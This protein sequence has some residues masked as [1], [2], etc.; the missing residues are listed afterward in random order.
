MIKLKT[1]L[2]KFNDKLKAQKAD[3]DKKIEIP[4]VQEIKSIQQLI[5]EEKKKL[6]DEFNPRK[7]PTFYKKL[8][9]ALFEASWG[10]QMMGSYKQILDIRKEG[11]LTSTKARI[12][13]QRMTGKGKQSW[14][15]M[16]WMIIGYS[17]IVI[18]LSAIIVPGFVMNYV[19]IQIKNG[20]WVEIPITNEAKP[21]VVEEAEDFNDE[22]KKED[23]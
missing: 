8:M 9:K 19:K 17:F 2:S 22:F 23:L 1:Q 16:V 15:N 13:K 3:L 5:I 21:T 14:L 11:I 12:E 10:K 7:G 20:E 6:D 4:L 18:T